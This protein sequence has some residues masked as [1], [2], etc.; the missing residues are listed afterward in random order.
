M[1]VDGQPFTQAWQLTTPDNPMTNPWDIRII[2]NNTAAVTQGDTALAVFYAR[3]LSAAPSLGAGYVTL[4]V[5]R[6]G[7]PYTKSAVTPLVLTNDWKRYE[8]PFSMAETYAAGGAYSIQFWITYGPQVIQLGGVSVMNY[9]QAV[10]FSSLPLTNWPYEGHQPDAPWRAAAA[11]RIEQI[12]KAPLRV[13]VRDDQGKP[14]A[15][16]MVKVRMKKHAF[17]FG[18]AVAAD[19]LNDTS[20]NGDKY[21]QMIPQLFNHAV[22]END[23]KWPDWEGDRNKALGALQWLHDRG[24]TVRGHNLIWPG[25]S[26]LPADVQS[27][28]RAGNA[29]ALRTRINNHFNDEVAA[30]KG[31]VVDWDVINEPVTNKDVQRVLGDSE[32]GAWYKLARS[33]DGTPKL[34][35]NDYSIIAAGGN[36]II[37]QNA[38]YNTIQYLLSIGAPVDGIGMQEHFDSNLTPPD[39]VLQVLDR[40]ATFGKDIKIT[41]FHININDEQLQADYTRDLLTAVFSHSSVKGFLMWGFWAGRHW[42]PDGA[43]YRLDWS[44]KPNA[45]VWQDLVYNQWWTNADGATGVDGAYAT[46]GFL[47]DYDVEVTVNGGAT[48]YPLQVQAGGVNTVFVGPKVAPMLPSNGVVNAASFQGGPVAPGEMVTIWTANLTGVPDAS[49]VYFDGAAA[50]SFGG[51]SDRVSSVVPT[52]VSGTTKIRLSHL[53]VMSDPVSFPV[54]GAVPGVF[55]Y[56]AGTGQVVAVNNQDGG[57]SFNSKDI[58]AKR[59]SILTVFLTGDGSGD[60]FQVSLGGVDCPVQYRGS[61][62]PG[63]TQVNF[64]VPAGRRRSRDSLSLS[65]NELQRN[66]IVIVRILSDHWN[67][68]LGAAGELPAGRG[69]VAEFNVVGVNGGEDDLGGF[70][71]NVKAYPFRAALHEDKLAGQTVVRFASFPAFRDDD[72]DAT[73]RAWSRLFRRLGFSESHRGLRRFPFMRQR[74][75]IQGVAGCAPGG[76]ELS[77]FQ[78][79]HGQRM[80]ERGLARQD[81]HGDFVMLDGGVLVFVTGVHQA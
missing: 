2:C 48:T 49:T 40:F 64:D 21:R 5:E 42:L 38:F 76:R 51:L 72:L 29:D 78:V 67:T 34:Y 35:V 46:R 44:A 32:M 43:M 4:D 75:G 7:N 80:P 68:F 23:L 37:H 25:M 55:T 81:I 24:I 57:T 10:P 39:R 56:G 14:V 12:R 59:G 11:A 27:L 9:G 33:L 79:R 41:E 61:I 45:Q 66:Q 8:V 31:Q 26:Y 22:L 30:V 71:F 73:G 20:S 15:G 58:P 28:V 17:P 36:D 52:T 16:A 65:A 3:T 50:Q 77:G 69:E 53:G 6:N 62:F 13:V 63:V 74:R 1:S 70:T 18:S 54:T 60:S 47:G 19:G